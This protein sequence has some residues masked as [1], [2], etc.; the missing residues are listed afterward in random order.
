MA[1]PRGHSHSH[2]N[3]HS[4]MPP[5][6]FDSFT[7]R[8]SEL[9]DSR[10]NIRTSFCVRENTMLYTSRIRNAHTRTHIPT[11]YVVTESSVLLETQV[12]RN[13]TRAHRCM[14]APVQTMILAYIH[15]PMYTHTCL[16]WEE[17]TKNDTTCTHTQTR[18]NVCYMYICI[19]VHACDKKKCWNKSEKCTHTRYMWVCT[20]HVHIT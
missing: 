3:S 9:N 13:S 4:H 11:R 18:A 8:G 2:S 12:Q 7:Q 15:V 19:E 14:Y 10:V 16:G 1:N 17:N 6:L 5:S 20:W